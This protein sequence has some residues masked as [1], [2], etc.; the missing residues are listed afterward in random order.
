M[1]KAPDPGGRDGKRDYPNSPP[2]HDRHHPLSS[3]SPHCRRAHFGFNT[4]IRQSAMSAA[5]TSRGSAKGKGKARAEPTERDPLLPSSSRS[6]IIGHEPQT[7][8]PRW[9]SILYTI[10]ITIFS[11]LF[12][13][14]LFVAL[15]A[16]S[17]KPSESELQ[18]LPKTAFSYAGPDNVQVLN[19]TNEGILVNVTLRCGIDVDTALGITHLDDDE[20]AEAIQRG[21]RGTGAEWWESLRRWTASR[22]LGQL[23]TR[24]IEVN[25][26]DPIYVF[27]RHFDTPP[28]LSLQVLDPLFVPLVPGVQSRSSWL[29]TMSF[30]ALA[31]PIASTGQLWDFVQHAWAEGEVKVVVGI[32]KVEARLPE[33]A[34]WAKYAQAVQEDLVMSL[35]VPGECPS[36]GTSPHSP[37]PH[38]FPVLGL[39]TA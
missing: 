22:A 21:E 14:G 12:A 35:G 31:R 18:A 24:S 5:S 32:G 13:A 29:E 15:L 10:L 19:V 1:Q 6:V 37:V 2:T 9:R 39:G 25:I 26:S 4:S 11:L 3:S 30:T 20:K 36:S 23:S 16:Y 38:P 34:W 7:R 33:R 17:F 28:L 27:P 8:T